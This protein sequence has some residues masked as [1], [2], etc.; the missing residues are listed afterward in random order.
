M[1]AH[2]VSEAAMAFTLLA[3]AGAFLGMVLA[4][5]VGGAA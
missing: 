1:R 4:L 5:A 3:L 2:D